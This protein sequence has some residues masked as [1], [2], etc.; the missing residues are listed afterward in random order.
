M[1]DRKAAAIA[2]TS[3][4][5][6]PTNSEV[7]ASA[8][9]SAPPVVPAEIPQYFLPYKGSSPPVYHPVLMGHLQARYVDDK[10]KIDFTE[11]VT[12]A[13]PI[14]TDVVPVK[15]EDGEVLGFDIESLESEPVANAQ[16]EELVSVASKPRSYAGWTKDL[17]T[18]ICATRR[19]EVT[20]E[21]SCCSQVACGGR[22]AR[23]L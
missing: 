3:S 13:T 22:T 9:A 5:I 4:K 20:A 15:W 18:Y 2:E 17:S 7:M 12:V 11:D 19:L 14:S 16:F 6:G 1:A 23:R 10:A 21:R 8:V